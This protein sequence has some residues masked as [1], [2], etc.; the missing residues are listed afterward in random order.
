MVDQFPSITATIEGVVFVVLV[1]SH[2]S[3]S[4]V[5]GV[6]N[7]ALKIRIEEPPTDNR[8][9]AALCEYLAHLLKTPRSAVRIP[10]G[11]R[12][13]IKR[14]EVRGITAKQVRDLLLHHA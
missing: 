10:A 6:A 7:G 11:D 13:R 3:N 1:Q 4:E 5:V 9:N 2:A 14:V 8:A 12:S